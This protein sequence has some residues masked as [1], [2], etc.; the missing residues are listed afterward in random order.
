VVDTE[1]AITGE[2]V[3]AE[4]GA[5]AVEPAED[6]YVPAAQLMH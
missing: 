3:P 1:A 4:Q 2:Y 6:E 5:Q